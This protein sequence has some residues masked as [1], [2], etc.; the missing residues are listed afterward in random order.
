LLVILIQIKVMNIHSWLAS[1]QSFI[2]CRTI[3][4]D[5]LKLASACF[6][7]ASSSFTAAFK[8]RCF[9]R[10]FGLP[11]ESFGVQ[12]SFIVAPLTILL[13]VVDCCVPVVTAAR[14]DWCS[15]WTDLV[16]D[17]E[18]WACDFCLKL[19]ETVSFFNNI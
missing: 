9:T 8:V 18:D 11:S 14:V 17:D 3:R 5:L 4:R 6:S 10:S 7:A 1:C 16:A 15:S 12:S 13:S 2:C 19:E